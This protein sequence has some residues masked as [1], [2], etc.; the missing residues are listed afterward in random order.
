MTRLFTLLEADFDSFFA[1]FAIPTQNY[2]DQ[3][4][5]PEKNSLLFKIN[6]IVPACK[7]FLIKG[8]LKK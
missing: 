2:L 3:G 7:E 8:S 1:A 4:F 5:V 6:V